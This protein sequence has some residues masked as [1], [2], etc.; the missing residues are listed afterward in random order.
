MEMELTREK[1]INPFTDFG[2]KR[3]FGEEVN[4]DILLDF[5][6]ELLREQHG[7]LT[8]LSYMKTEQ[9]GRTEEERRAI[10]D[11]YCETERGE[12]ILIEMQKTKQAFFKDRSLYY[13]T[14]PIQ[15]Q[16]RRSDWDYRLNAVY[17]IGILDFVFDDDKLDKDK[18]RYDVKLSDID[19]KSVFFDKLTFIYLEMPKFTKAVGELATRFEKWLYVLKNL[20]KLDRLPDSLRE[21]AF[22]RVFQVAE[23]A[24]MSRQEYQAYE[25]SLKAYRDMQNSIDT[26]RL[27]GKAEGLV[28]GELKG[29][30][31]GKI[32]GRMEVAKNLKDNGV[33][34]EIIM[35][36]TGLSREE[37]DAV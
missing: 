4:K 1:Y 26:A 27:E 13:S 21:Q 17:T 23:I 31:E 6:N 32:E 10:F 14:F 12:K 29:K 2:F 34:I 22:E 37:V 33:S 3:L 28:E 24:K 30:I 36:S 9:F 20:H 11:I 25:D 19:T 15:E 18:F 7:T 8:G 5:L 35:K 16:A